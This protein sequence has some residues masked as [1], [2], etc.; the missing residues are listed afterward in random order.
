MFVTAVKTACLPV[1]IAAVTS[2][3]GVDKQSAIGFLGDIDEVPGVSPHL[4]VES[5][6]NRLLCHWLLI[7]GIG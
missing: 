3:H 5:T 7:S 2:A 1:P 4:K 6:Q